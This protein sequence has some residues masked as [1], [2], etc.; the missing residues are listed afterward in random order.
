MIS[1]LCGLVVTSRYRDKNRK[2]FQV[3]IDKRRRRKGKEASVVK[4]KSRVNWVLRL[5]VR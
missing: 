3:L 2:N 5:R 1:Y 4:N